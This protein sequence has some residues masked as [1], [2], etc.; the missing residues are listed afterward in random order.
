MSADHARTVVLRRYP[1]ALRRLGLIPLLAAGILMAVGGGTAAL[2]VAVLLAIPGTV[3]IGLRRRHEIDPGARCERRIAGWGP[4]VRTRSRAFPPPVAIALGP[5]RWVGDE[6]PR[7]RVVPLTV[8]AAD[9][10]REVVETTDAVRARAW[11]ERLA[12]AWRVPLRD[13]SVGAPVERDADELDRPLLERIDAEDLA[14][15]IPPGARIR[16]AG[17]ADGVR[18]VIDRRPLGCLIPALLPLLATIGWWWLGVAAAPAPAER[19]PWLPTLVA[20]VTASLP[21]SLLAV[22]LSVV[23]LVNVCVGRVA[24]VVHVSPRLGIRVGRRRIAPD[25]LEGLRFDRGEGRLVA[26]ADDRELDLGRGLRDDELTAL[27]ALVLRA[28]RGIADPG[29]SPAPPG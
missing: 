26:I 14:A 5:P 21:W 29:R 7:Q 15:P 23:L 24:S 28:L 20:V 10:E 4:F 6:S 16:V 2:I 27:R 18:V 1:P 17:R 22:L 3:L 13:A 12:R 9:G 25:R 11:G 8:V 19:T